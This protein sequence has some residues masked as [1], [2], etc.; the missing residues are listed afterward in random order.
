MAFG[1]CP[2]CGSK[3]KLTC[4]KAYC[5][6]CRVELE[7]SKR[8]R[9]LQ[10]IATLGPSLLAIFV[11]QAGTPDIIAKE[12]EDLATELFKYYMYLFVVAWIASAV[13]D[14]LVRRCWSTYDGPKN[15]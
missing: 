4:F 14:R 7:E 11:G 13:L 10:G 6:R 15:T 3:A 8:T 5:D 9:V 1:K 2:S 12:P